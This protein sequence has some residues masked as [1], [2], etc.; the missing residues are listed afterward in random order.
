MD[1]LAGFLLSIIRDLTGYWLLRMCGNE[2]PGG[3]AM[4]LAGLA[5]WMLV[6]VLFCGVAGTA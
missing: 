1:T 2:H 5:F 6:L 3:F 4:T